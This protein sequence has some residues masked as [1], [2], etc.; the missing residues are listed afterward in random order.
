MTETTALPACAPRPAHRRNPLLALGLVV[1]AALLAGLPAPAWAAE[2]DG[3]NLSAWWALP[4]AGMLLSIAILPLAIPQ[5]WHHHFGKIAAGWALLLLVPFAM[6]QGAGVTGGMLVHVLL[7]EY[8]PFIVLLTALFTVA[9][10]IYVRGSSKSQINIWCWPIGSGE[11]FGYRNDPT[12]PAAVRAGV[13]PK[14][15]AD[16]APGK[17]NRFR[18]R[19]QGDRLTVNLNGKTVVENAQ[20]P[21]LPNKGPIALQHHGA[22]IEFANIYLRELKPEAPKSE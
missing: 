2:V 16:A 7:A 3:R 11:V 20:M 8:I 21:G 1:A 14:E 22:P 10:G 12:Q 15:K 4:F 19:L 5:I 6:T 17:W 18:I 9:G 13:T